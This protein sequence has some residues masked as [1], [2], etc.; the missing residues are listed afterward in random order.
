MRITVVFNQMKK[1]IA[2]QHN[3]NVLYVHCYMV[4]TSI[5]CSC[6]I[7][8]YSRIPYINCFPCF[9]QNSK[10]CDFST[11]PS[12]FLRKRSVPSVNIMSLCPIKKT[13]ED[14]SAEP[15][16]LRYCLQDCFKVSKLLYILCLYIYIH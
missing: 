13:Y 12:L 4:M 15:L 7:L 6:R 2:A 10:L 5:M 8:I 11:V 14:E 9:V 16:Y 1:Y 3:C